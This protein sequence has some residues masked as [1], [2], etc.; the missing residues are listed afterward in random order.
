MS[1]EMKVNGGEKTRLKASRCSQENERS[2]IT[3]STCHVSKQHWVTINKGKTRN[4]VVLAEA[5]INDSIAVSLSLNSA[6]HHF[7]NRQ[8]PS[9]VTFWLLLF[10]SDTRVLRSLHSAG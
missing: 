9:S 1:N 8:Q 5:R 4:C 7:P 2:G 10:P 3:L 6:F